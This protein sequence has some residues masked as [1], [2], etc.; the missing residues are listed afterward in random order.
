LGLILRIARRFVPHPAIACAAPLLACAFL[1]WGF[2][3]NGFNMS[4]PYDLP[5]VFFSALAIWFIV[6]GQYWPLL[7]TI[8]LGTLNKETMV[9]LVPVYVLQSL[10]EGGPRAR[11]WLRSI[12][13]GGAFAACYLGPRVLMGTPDDH[14]AL[15]FSSRADQVLKNGAIAHTRLQSNLQELRLNHRGRFYQNVYWVFL[16]HLP[17]LIGWRRLPRQLRL[18]YAGVPFLLVPLFVF[19][20]ICELRLYNEIIPLGAVAATCVLG[21][22]QQVEA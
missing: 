7:A 19:G 11:R 21:N 18:L 5:V 4:Y 14:A 10:L 17:A 16:L 12:L 22:F 1:P 6:S 3:E 20:N 8:V 9:W 2:L 15:T 13:L